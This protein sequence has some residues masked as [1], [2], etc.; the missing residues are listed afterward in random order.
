MQAKRKICG[1]CGLEQYIWSNKKGKRYCLSCYQKTFPSQPII[2]T[3]IKRSGKPINSISKHRLPELKKY[4]EVRDKYLEENPVCEFPSCQSREIQ[5][6]HKKGRSGRLLYNPIF[7]CALCD[8]HHRWT[9]LNFEE[10]V[11]LGLLVS[12]LES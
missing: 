2:R 1:V 9:H 8:F 4:R 7:F 6:H 5:L 3:A 10:A 12:R 11:S